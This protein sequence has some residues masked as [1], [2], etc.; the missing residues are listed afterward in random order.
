MIN[1]LSSELWVSRLRNT[2]VHL[3]PC[4]VRAVRYSPGMNGPD[5]GLEKLRKLLPDLSEEKLSEVRDN[6]RAY[7]ELALAVYEEKYMKKPGMEQGRSDSPT[8][9]GQLR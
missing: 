7:V 9:G 2:C 6:L 3:S 1:M 5:D 8:V 4:T